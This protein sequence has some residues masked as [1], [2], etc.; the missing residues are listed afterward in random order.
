MYTIIITLILSCTTVQH[1]KITLTVKK[2][3]QTAYKD[4]KK[5]IKD[6]DDNPI[7]PERQYWKNLIK[8]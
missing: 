6:K 4:E 1:N 3:Q 8:P 2:A 7:S 5:V